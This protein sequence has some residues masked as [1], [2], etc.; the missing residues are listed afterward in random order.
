MKRSSCSFD[1]GD[2]N[3]RI[4]ALEIVLQKVLEDPHHDSITNV[5]YSN[6]KN[7]P[8][9]SSTT[10]ELNSFNDRKFEDSHQLKKT[11]CHIFR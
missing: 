4:K 8:N 9:H 1:L 5:N 2:E 3:T 7:F 10:N 11:F 6:E